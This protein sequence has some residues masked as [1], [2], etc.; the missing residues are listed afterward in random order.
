M[1][2][3]KMACS[4]FVAVDLFELLIYF[5]LSGDSFSLLNGNERLVLWEYWFAGLKSG[6]ILNSTFNFN[7]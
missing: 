4:V 1:D 5:S 2:I 6:C 7:A 3:K